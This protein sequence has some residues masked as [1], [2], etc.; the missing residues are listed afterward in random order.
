MLQDLQFSIGNCFRNCTA[1]FYNKNS[2]KLLKNKYESQIQNCC[3]TI[4]KE[5]TDYAVLVKGQ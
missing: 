2:S 4:A 1:Y 5:T 3:N